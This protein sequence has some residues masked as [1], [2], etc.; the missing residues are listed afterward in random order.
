MA[1]NQSRHEK[2]FKQLWR[3]EL[4]H[5]WANLK[6][7]RYNMAYSVDLLCKSCFTT[8]QRYLFHPRL[9]FFYLLYSEKESNI[10]PFSEFWFSD[11]STSAIRSLQ[12]SGTEASWVKRAVPVLI[13]PQLKY[14]H[15]A[16]LLKKAWWCVGRSEEEQEET[17]L[18]WIDQWSG[19]V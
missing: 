16:L 12:F 7:T 11:S 6:K 15:M 13:W 9:F 2:H 3:V 10:W 17:V 19:T 8:P 18:T 1:L 14:N 4:S 5:F